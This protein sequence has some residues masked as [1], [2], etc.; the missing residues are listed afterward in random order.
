M[1]KKRVLMLVGFFTLL[2][3]VLTVERFLSPSQVSPQNEVRNDTTLAQVEEDILA[4]EYNILAGDAVTYQAPNRLNGWRTHFNTSGVQMEPRVDGDWSL[5]MTLT[6]MGDEFGMTAVEPATLMVDGNQI[7]YSRGTVTEW[8]INNNRGLEQG[9]TIE[10]HPS[11]A[12]AA[13]LHLDV[14]LGG[15]LTGQA[16]APEVI[17]FATSEGEHILTYDHL[18][19]F[20]VNANPLP[21]SMQLFTAADGSQSVRLSVETA[22]AVFPIVVDPLAS[23]ADWIVATAQDD[24]LGFS[25]S[26]A[27][28][29]DGDGFDDVLVG[30]PWFDANGNNKGATFLYLGSDEGL[31]TVV[32]W[33]EIGENAND[34]FGFAV[35]EAGDI[36]NDGFDDVI[37]GAPGRDAAY[38]YYGSATGLDSSTEQRVSKQADSNFGY[39]VSGAGDVNDDGNADII[40]GAPNFKNGSGVNRGRA[41]VYYGSD[42]GIDTSGEDWAARSVI[43]GSL[44]G[45]SVTNA[46]DIN[47]DGVDDIAIGD[48][49]FNSN[50]EE[51]GSVHVFWGARTTGLANGPLADQFQDDITLDDPEF[52]DTEYGSSVSA[53]GDVDGNEVDDLIIGAP[54]TEQ[55]VDVVGAAYVVFGPMGGQN[56]FPTEAA[57]YGIL[58]GDEF[59]FSVAGA[60]DVNNDGFA[61]VIVGSPGYD[62]SS[63][64]RSSN[65]QGNEGRAIVY[66]GDVN[67]A[68]GFL[69]TLSSLDGDATGGEFG[70][71][72]NTAGDVND[73]GFVDVI[74]G[75]P[76]YANGS[77]GSGRAFAYHGTG[78]VMGLTAVNDG[79]TTIG[80]ETTFNANSTSPISGLNDYAWDFGDG[81]VG[82]GSE[83]THTYGATGFYTATL[84]VFNPLNQTTQ[85]AVT[86]VNVVEEVFIDPTNGGNAT[87][88]DNNG[89]STNVDVPPGAVNSPITIEF[90]PLNIEDLGSRGVTI[91]GIEQ[92][93]PENPTQFFF[94][95]EPGT[96]RQL[97][98][99]MVYVEPTSNKSA[100]G[101]LFQNN[102]VAGT[103]DPDHFCFDQPV[104][105]KLTYDEANLNGQAENELILVVWDEDI[106]AWVD[107]TT[108]CDDPSGYTRDPANNMITLQICHISRFGMVG[109]N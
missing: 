30:A 39:S 52:A 31:D 17:E 65:G 33:Q 63:S 84:S 12:G 105:L 6:H 67:A 55:S 27:G 58:D 69:P 70:F 91:A 93:L 90:T 80:E 10:S 97:F 9:F 64:S 44:F 57:L 60:G 104:T 96:P 4:L 100:Q 1:Y 26:T 72:V 101:N 21:A 18:Y 28:D 47:G 13:M 40:V 79:P 86:L 107:A 109:A 99:P 38:I 49:Y 34:E 41:Y 53:A 19:A 14:A 83:T 25:V 37:I 32:F 95:L 76:S 3:L 2:S 56:P 108:T 20:D 92:P 87:F 74:V 106:N 35:S 59:G 94:D 36:D 54:L 8:Y 43:D 50:Q 66:L 29:V 102:Q 23:S 85:T 68:Q 51:V 5:E 11:G 42:S 78:P 88:N 45:T 22:N 46:G 62:A 77:V 81:S 73:D 15:T 82:S 103:C 89:N 16:I 71:S 98:L 7:S 61:D 75:A 24:L 48:P